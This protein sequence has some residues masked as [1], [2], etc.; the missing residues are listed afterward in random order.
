MRVTIKWWN[1]HTNKLKYFSSKYFDEQKN[2]FGKG[3]STGS[4]LINVTNVYS[5]TTLNNDLSDHPFIE[6]NIFD[7]AVNIPPWVNPIVIVA[8]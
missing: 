3:W 6:D 8:Q 4:A 1:P 5:L 2:K 7:A